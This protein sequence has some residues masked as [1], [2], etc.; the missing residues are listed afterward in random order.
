MKK[1]LVNLAEELTKEGYKYYPDWSAWMREGFNTRTKRKEPVF[2]R[3][4]GLFTITDESIEK[5]QN[6][7]E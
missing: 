7:E 2:V 5:I 3:G 4:C 1:K 6:G